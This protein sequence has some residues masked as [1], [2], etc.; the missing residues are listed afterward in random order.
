MRAIVVLILGLALML[1][2]PTVNAA[3]SPYLESQLSNPDCQQLVSTV[4]WKHH[5]TAT[6]EHIFAHPKAGGGIGIDF[7]LNEPV[8]G[9]RGI[10][11]KGTSEVVY[12]RLVE[13]GE[14]WVMSVRLKDQDGVRFASTTS[15]V[16]TI[17]D[18]EP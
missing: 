9:K 15:P 17:E 4:N 10:K 1:G 2:A 7:I 3:P 14:E 11:R 8:G 12:D 6:V 18:C 13:T 16:I 5:P